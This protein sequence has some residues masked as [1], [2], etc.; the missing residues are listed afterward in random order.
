MLSFM[1]ESITRLRPGTKTV[2]GSSVPDWSK[3][4]QSTISGCSIQPAS[5]SLSQD[6]RILGITEGLTAY[7]PAGSDVLASDRIIYDG[8][9]YIINGE[10]KA[11]TSPSGAVS[12][13]QLQLERWSG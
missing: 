8:N 13:I 12:N 1:T 7:I 3:A 11:W 6:G 5:T 4:T 2:R 10:P 9:T